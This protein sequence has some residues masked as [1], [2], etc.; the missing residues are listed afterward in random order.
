MQVSRHLLLI[1]KSQLDVTCVHFAL[2]NIETC[3]TD[4][5]WA[6]LLAIN[7]AANVY[8]LQYSGMRFLM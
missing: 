3:M 6:I 1:K 5:F 7:L 4:I 2:L 8:G